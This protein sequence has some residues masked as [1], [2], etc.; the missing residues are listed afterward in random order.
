MVLRSRH[1]KV[2][3]Q[4]LWIGVSYVHDFVCWQF[5]ETQSGPFY[6]ILQCYNI[7]QAVIIDNERMRDNLIFSYVSVTGDVLTTTEIST[8]LHFI[9]MSVECDGYEQNYKCTSLTK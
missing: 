8:S 3:G 5:T 9:I 6:N 4:V 7:W 1:T 2:S